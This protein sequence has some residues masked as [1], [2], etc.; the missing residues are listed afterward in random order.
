[1]PLSLKRDRDPWNQ[2]ERPRLT[3]STTRLEHHHTPP[4]QCSWFVCPPNLLVLLFFLILS[5]WFR[6]RLLLSISKDAGE[7]AAAMKDRWRWWRAYGVGSLRWYNGL[8]CRSWIFICTQGGRALDVPPA[9][10]RTL[11][12]ASGVD[13]KASKRGSLLLTRCH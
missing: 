3:S 12:R 8:L 13:L 7:V 1:M 4:L 9:C 6:S 2:I 10:R 5:L 11:L